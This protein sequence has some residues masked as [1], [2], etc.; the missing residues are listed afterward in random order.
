MA[1]MWA[2]GGGYKRKGQF[3]GCGTTEGVRVFLRACDDDDD[4]NN[5]GHDGADCGN[6]DGRDDNDDDDDRDEY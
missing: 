5:H 6:E 3:L 1:T 2:E 4:D